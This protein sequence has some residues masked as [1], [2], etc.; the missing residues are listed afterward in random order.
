VVLPLDDDF[1]KIVI[2]NTPLL[3]V[4]APIE[5]AKGSFYNTTNIPIMD[6]EQRHLVGTE[7]KRSGN[8]S[9]V[10]L[11]E[12]LIKNEGKEDRVVQ[13][14]SFIKENPQAKLFCFRGGQRSKIS[15][16]WLNESGINITRLKG[17][18]KAFRSF[19]MEESLDI[20]AKTP[21]IILGGHTGSGKTILLS[22]FDN[23]IDLEALANHRGSSFGNFANKQPAQIDFENNLS[24]KL[25]QFQESKHKNLILEHESQNIGK[26]F[27]P[28]PLYENL[29]DGKLVI[30]E[31]PL[32]QR[33]AITYHEYITLELKK[34]TDIYNENGLKKWNKYVVKSLDKI[35]KRIGSE[36]HKEL[37]M[38]FEDAY[39]KHGTSYASSQYKLFIAKLLTHYYDPMYDYQIQK[40]AIEIVFRGNEEE[41]VEYL[42]SL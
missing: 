28:K 36:L 11:A 7:Y 16:E 13:W 12:E 30:L 29:M 25:I 33:V 35:K 19:L 21:T 15:Q 41:V 31:T 20:S 40:T 9:A 34:Y 18:Y 32:E 42:R 39:K 2:N 38:L 24:Y 8:E 3:D 17:G 26:E 23:F 22:K 37:Y 5:F 10:K 14:R 1:R 27:I 4:R 6:D